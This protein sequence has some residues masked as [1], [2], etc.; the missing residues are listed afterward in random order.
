MAL[1]SQ[2]KLEEAVWES[3]RGYRV[4][5]RVNSGVAEGH[6]DKL[7]R[8]PHNVA[9]TPLDRLLKDPPHD[10]WIFSHKALSGPPFPLRPGKKSRQQ[11]RL[12]WAF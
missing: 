5:L 3:S 10:P 8:S 4:E 7:V 2:K 1:G 6:L 9:C 11:Q 12:H